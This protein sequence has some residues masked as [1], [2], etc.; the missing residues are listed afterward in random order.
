LTLK[1][2]LITSELPI[3]AS[4]EDAQVGVV[5]HGTVSKVMEKGVLVDFFGGMRALIPAGEAAYVSFLLKCSSLL[6]A[7]C[8]Q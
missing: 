1:K 8:V 4:I 3:V 6:T 7:L 2:Q 5:T